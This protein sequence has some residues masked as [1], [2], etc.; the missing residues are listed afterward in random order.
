MNGLSKRRTVASASSHWS[1]VHQRCCALLF[2]GDRLLVD[3]FELSDDDL[4]KLVAI[5]QLGIERR[6]IGEMNLQISTSQFKVLDNESGTC[7][8]IAMCAS[9]VRWRSRSSR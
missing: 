4:D 1:D 6:S 7:R 9:P 5:G 2:E 8:S 3:R